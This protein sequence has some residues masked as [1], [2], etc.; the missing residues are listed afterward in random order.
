[1]MRKMKRTLL[2][3]A[4]YLAVVACGPQSNPPPDSHA[5]DVRSAW[6]QI[7]K[8]WS[9]RD[10]AELA[11]GESGVALKMDTVRIERPAGFQAF[12]S[13]GVLDSVRT[14]SVSGHPE[15]FIANTVEHAPLPSPLPGQQTPAPQSVQRLSV[16]KRS[17]GRW[18]LDA[19]VILPPYD[20]SAYRPTPPPGAASPARQAHPTPPPALQLPDLGAGSSTPAVSSALSARAAVIPDQEASAIEGGDFSS[21]A[22][23]MYTTGIHDGFRSYPVAAGGFAPLD[24]TTTATAADPTYLIGASGSQALLFFT[25]NTKESFGDGKQCLKPELQPVFPPL[26]SS[27]HYSQVEI[28]RVDVFL[29]AIPSSG[30]PKV[31]A[32]A[33]TII[34]A[35]GKR[36]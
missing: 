2:A 29:A 28:D 6:S 5:G 21:L 12:P 27:D 33:G 31:V 15:L 26:T 10:A 7:L 18:T 24:P 8:A 4:L 34:N 20:P 32:E 25:V 19:Y 36:C 14:Y 30:K 35:V 16:F 11:A 1:M 13:L 3:L 22:A 17:G 23:G 9:D